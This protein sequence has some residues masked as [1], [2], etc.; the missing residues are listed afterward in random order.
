MG[1][2]KQGREGRRRDGH[3]KGRKEEVL[4]NIDI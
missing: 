2:G 1:G 4:I 3:E